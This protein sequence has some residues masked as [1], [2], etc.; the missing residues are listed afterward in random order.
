MFKKTSHNQ[1][2]SIFELTAIATLSNSYTLI[3]KSQVNIRSD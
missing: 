2:A 3:D 1:I